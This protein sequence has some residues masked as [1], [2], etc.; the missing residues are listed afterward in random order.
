MVYEKNY[1]DEIS[2]KSF[3]DIDDWK[4]IID[5]SIEIKNYFVTEDPLETG[6][7]KVLNFGH[8]IGHAVESYSFQFGSK[9]L[10]HGEAVAIGIICE[11]Y[12]SYKHAGL[13]EDEL[14]EIVQYVSANFEQY[15][16]RPGYFENL[17]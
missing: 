2:G 7:R 13:S 1:W 8:T 16:F 10:L 5:L 11:S 12:I 17:F 15:T 9:A 14:S 3:K 4:E 6:F